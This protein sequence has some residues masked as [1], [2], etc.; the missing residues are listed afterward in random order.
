MKVKNLKAERLLKLPTYMFAKFDRHR[1]VVR[2]RGID[3]I[4]LS[5]GDPDIPPP[6][7][8]IQYLK[9]A[10]NQPHIHRYPPYRG[11]RDFCKAITLW[12][13]QKNIVLDADN[14]VWSL[15]GSKEGIVHLVWALVNPGDYVLIPNPCYPA[16]RSAVILAGGIPIDMPLVRE[17]NFLPDLAHIKS[18]IV[19]RAK[20]MLLNYPHNPTS[21]DAPVTFYEDVVQF[22]RRYNII[23][24]QDAAYSE[25]YFGQRPVSFLSVKGAKD[26]GVEINS[27]SKTFCIAGWRLGWAAGNKQIIEALGQIKTNID[28]GA[29]MAL[30]SAVA[31]MITQNPSQTTKELD[32]IRNIYK[33]RKDLMIKGLKEARFEPIASETTFYI[34]LPLASGWN[35]SMKFSEYLLTKSYIHTA[36]GIGFGKYGDGYIRISLT[37]PEETLKKSIKRLKESQRDKS[38][39]K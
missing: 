13:K 33:Q 21:A 5:I 32:R 9:S 35:S 20:L 10:L 11:T 17:N 31:R 30:Q 29:F 19:R 27:F 14:E 1:D 22:A 39:C 37:S 12:Y 25:I 28:S 6:A 4:D 24:C 7:R 26:V 34:W 23:V 16:Y 36:A 3:L 8:L 2:A 15:I 38:V 18:A